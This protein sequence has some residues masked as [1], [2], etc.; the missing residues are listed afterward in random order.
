MMFLPIHTQGGGVVP[1]G[2][3]VEKV[4]PLTPHALGLGLSPPLPTPSYRFHSPP[5]SP[6]PLARI[7]QPALPF[8][9]AFFIYII[10]QP[11]RS[12]TIPDLKDRGT[13]WQILLNASC[14]LNKNNWR[15]ITVKN[16]E[17]WE[18]AETATPACPSSSTTWPRCTW[19]WG[20]S[21][22]PFGTLTGAFRKTEGEKVGGESCGC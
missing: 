10:S 17:I 14:T 1:K 16:P 11:H 8:F 7:D 2:R 12:F 22:R 13:I 9:G 6:E 15:A 4:L 19:P 20:T 21:G 5:P 18:P 3:D